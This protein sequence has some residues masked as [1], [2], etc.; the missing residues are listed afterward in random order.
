M[1]AVPV[2]PTVLRAM[3]KGAKGLLPW[4]PVQKGR[5]LQPLWPYCPWLSSLQPLQVYRQPL[6]LW[7]RPQPLW[8]L[9]VQASI[10]LMTLLHVPVPRHRDSAKAHVWPTQLLHDC[11]TASVR[12]LYSSRFQSPWLAVAG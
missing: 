5:F 2:S 10:L 4:Q 8:M 1:W 6:W 3:A 11:S 12:V 7:L 9:R